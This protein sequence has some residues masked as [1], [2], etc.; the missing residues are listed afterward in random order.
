MPQVN[1]DPKCTSYRKGNK[2]DQATE[3]L[4]KA[5]G[6]YLSIV[7]GLQELQHFEDYFSDYK[8]IFYDGMSTGRFIFT[9]NS[10]SSKT[11]YLL[12]DADTGHY[13]VL[14]NIKTAFAKKVYM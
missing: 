13:N 14:T 10:L 3:D 2:L 6:I 1:G 5:S 8:I 11:L 12:Y 9:G 4:L 7:G